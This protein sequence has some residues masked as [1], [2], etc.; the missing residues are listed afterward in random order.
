M[1]VLRLLFAFYAV[2]KS[3][4]LFYGYY[5]IYHEDV[6]NCNNKRKLPFK[7]VLLPNISQKEESKES[8]WKMVY[9]QTKSNFFSSLDIFI[10]RIHTII[11]KL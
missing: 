10:K 2:I 1:G 3:L 7:G 5:E 4:L 9:I 11:L 6:K 8:F